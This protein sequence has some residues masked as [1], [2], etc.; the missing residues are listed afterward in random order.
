MSTLQVSIRLDL[1]V[2]NLWAYNYMPC[3]M[4][5]ERIYIYLQLFKY[6]LYECTWKLQINTC[7]GRS[8]T[9][10]I[11]SGNNIPHLVHFLVVDNPNS[12]LVTSSTIVQTLSP[13]VRDC[14]ALCLLVD[15]CIQVTCPC[16]I[17][18]SCTWCLCVLYRS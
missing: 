2:R 14:A 11:V 7:L 8:I 1:N 12:L 3:R 5:A 15:G 17:V 4:R 9:Y 10:Q 6:N 13:S 18:S 16:V